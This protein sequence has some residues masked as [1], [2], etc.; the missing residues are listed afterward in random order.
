MNLHRMIAD[1]RPAMREG[2]RRLDRLPPR[3]IDELLLVALLYALAGILL[4]LYGGYHAGFEWLHSALRPLFPDLAWAFLT[5]LGD[6]RV[7]LIVT[8]LFAR[9]HP[10]IFWSMLL[11]ALLAILYSRGLKHLVDAVRPSGIYPADALQVIGPRLR[12]HSFPSGHT[13]SV[14][15]FAGVLFAF[16]RTTGERALLLVVATLVGL[17]RVALGVHWPQD[18][19]A[20]AFG[21][22]VSAAL[23]VW[24]ARYWRAGLRPAVHLSLVILPLLAMP[25]L[26]YTDGGNPT[27]LWFTWPLVFAML[28][29]FV[30]DYLPWR[31]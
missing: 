12:A 17:S 8:L 16:A 31:R 20:G 7:L 4:G 3:R 14:F 26:L 15:V 29:Q 19:L 18:V 2:G 27:L 5:R 1:L 22:L 21:G 25:W 23:G 13:T 11:A 6:E 24:L 9:R 28:M 10:E 30:L